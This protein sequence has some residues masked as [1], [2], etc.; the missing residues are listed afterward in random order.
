MIRLLYDRK[1]RKAGV[2]ALITSSATLIYAFVSLYLLIPYDRGYYFQYY[3]TI[4]ALVASYGF[5]L[6]SFDHMVSIIY[7]VLIALSIL[8]IGYSIVAFIFA[9]KTFRKLELKPEQLRHKRVVF[10]LTGVF[11]FLAGDSAVNTFLS[12]C[13][14][15]YNVISYALFFI[16]LLAIVNAIKGNKALSFYIRVNEEQEKAAKAQE[17]R[18][19]F[20]NSEPPIDATITPVVEDT[21]V[22]EAKPTYST[23]DIDLES[24]YLSLANLEKKYKSGEISI[25]E[26]QEKKE[27]LL[28]KLNG[29]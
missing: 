5:D 21:V 2:Y 14:T 15:V 11:G 7:V 28:E 10:I 6:S 18:E 29:R 23:P 3:S 1:L 16:G 8:A 26:Y 24:L 17:R 12:S 20:S 13:F 19:E 27:K 9:F 4:E 22:E 25:E